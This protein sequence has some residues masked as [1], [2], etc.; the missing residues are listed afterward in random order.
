M[1]QMQSNGQTSQMQGYG[2]MPQMQSNDQTP[3][4]ENTQNESEAAA[5]AAGTDTTGEDQKPSAENAQ[6]ALKVQGYNAVPG[7][8]TGPTT[9]GY[10]PQLQ[11]MNDA[12]GN[13]FKSAD[14]SHDY[15]VD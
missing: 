2:Q 9:Q 8:Q 12:M 10:N 6:A 11:K 13:M 4:Q 7:D 5:S 1:P 15:E 14:T 3:I